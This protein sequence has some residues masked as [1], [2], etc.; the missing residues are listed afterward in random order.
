MPFRPLTHSA[1]SKA[2][3]LRRENSYT[4]SRDLQGRGSDDC[5]SG[6]RKSDED[7]NEA[8]ADQA[9]ELLLKGRT[10]GLGLG[11]SGLGGLSWAS[12]QP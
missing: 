1:G 10:G 9:A 7:N 8:K 6:I 3:A 5:R 2:M 11:L 12:I 4:D